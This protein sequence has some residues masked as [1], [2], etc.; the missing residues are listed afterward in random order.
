ME[1]TI[2]LNDKALANFTDCIS[3]ETMI[4]LLGDEYDHYTSPYLTAANRIISNPS[5]YGWIFIDWM[6]SMGYRKFELSEYP[7]GIVKINAHKR[8]NTVQKWAADWDMD[9]HKVDFIK[10]FC[11]LIEAVAIK[12]FG[13]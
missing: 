9:I 12:E 3:T 7:N 13:E 11:A 4:E 1:N 8:V 2:H 5:I 6:R 10:A